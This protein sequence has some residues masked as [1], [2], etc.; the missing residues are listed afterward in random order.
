MCK[1]LAFNSVLCGL[2]HTKGIINICY[3]TYGHRRRPDTY[4]YI[5]VHDNWEN[6]APN[7]VYVLLWK[8]LWGGDSLLIIFLFFNFD[9]YIHGKFATWDF[10]YFFSLRCY[11]MKFHFF[12]I[13]VYEIKRLQDFYRR[14]QF[15]RCCIFG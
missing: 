6:S 9:F 2:I 3:G 15:L 7:T 4:K 13:T 5:Y 11:T 1:R 10:R 14:N 12:F 8:G